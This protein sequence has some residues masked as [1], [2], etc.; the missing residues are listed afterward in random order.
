[1]VSRTCVPVKADRGGTPIT[2]DK[3]APRAPSGQA[4]APLMLEA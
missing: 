3:R 4:R 1:M 2:G